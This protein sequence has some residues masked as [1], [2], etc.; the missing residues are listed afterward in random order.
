MANSYAVED[1]ISS[2]VGEGRVTI[3]QRDGLWK[4]AESGANATALLG[5]LRELG[6]ES[7]LQTVIN[8]RNARFTVGE[9][10]E[11]INA[12][13]RQARG[14]MPSDALNQLAFWMIRSLS[15]IHQELRG[16]DLS[17]VRTNQLMTMAATF[18]TRAQEAIA[19]ADKIKTVADT[20][21]I[22]LG[23]MEEVRLSYRQALE[24]ESPELLP[25]IDSVLNTVKAKLDV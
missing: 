12:W 3:Q 19:Q 6:Y 23:T 5:Y 17:Q 4:L 18:S 22:I 14:L 8:W 11:E 25:I 9:R 2:A 7:G 15:D 10:A 21:D 24:K 20:K 16:R 1:F 13:T